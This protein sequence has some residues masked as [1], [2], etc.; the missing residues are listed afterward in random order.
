MAAPAEAVIV[1]A[2]SYLQTATGS[3]HDVTRVAGPEYQKACAALLQG[4]S[5]GLPQGTACLT[6]DQGQDYPLTA[7]KR[8]V[9]Q[10][11]TLRYF[12]GERIRATPDIVYHAARST[13]RVPRA[14]GC[15]TSG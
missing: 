8:K 13:R 12:N 10:A 7:G 5:D 9:I 4:H 2:N 1:S 11:I 3:A 14:G 15:C 6:G